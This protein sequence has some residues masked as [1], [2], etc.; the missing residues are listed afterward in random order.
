MPHSAISGDQARATRREGPHLWSNGAFRAALPGA[1]VHKWEHVERYSARLLRTLDGLLVAGAAAFGEVFAS[2]V[3]NQTAGCT[4]ADLRGS[5]HVQRNGFDYAWSHPLTRKE[6]RRLMKLASPSSDKEGR[7][8]NRWLH[9]V[10]GD[11]D[12]LAVAACASSENR[13]RPCELPA[14]GAGA[15]LWVGALRKLQPWL[16]QQ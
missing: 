9:G 14:E 5:G 16:Q 1:T 10:A 12:V 4:C 2:S 11:C 8:L 7:G 6:L 3:C 15:G 13:G